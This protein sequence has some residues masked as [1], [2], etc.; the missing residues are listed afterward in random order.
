M[1]LQKF[2]IVGCGGSGGATLRYLMDQLRADLRHLGVDS[3]PAAWQFVHIDAPATPDVGPGTLGSIT[4]LGGRYVSV[5][6]PQNS[7]LATW[8]SVAARMERNHALPSLIGWAPS[9]PRKANNVP[10]TNGAGQYRAIGRMLT[11]PYL[12][13][14]HEQLDTAYKALQQPTAWGEMPS[15]LHSGNQAVIPIVVSSMAGGAG[16]GIFL[17]ACRL[18]G[19]LHGIESS[20]LGLFLY[21]ADVFNELP[22]SARSGVEGNALGS[23]G[24]II[25]AAART[26][27]PLEQEML[28]A[29][30][31]PQVGMDSAPFGRVFPIGAMVG[32]DGAIFGD[33][34]MHGI[35]RGLGRALAG[36]MMSEQATDNYVNRIL[37][38][39]NPADTDTRHLGWAQSPAD[40]TWGSMGYASVS[41]GRDRYEEYAAQRLSR[42]AVDHLMAGHR[43]PGSQLPDTE[44]LAALID[45]QLPY[46]LPGIG[47]GHPGQGTGQWFQTEAFPDSVVEPIAR[48]SLADVLTAIGKDGGPALHWYGIVASRLAASRSGIRQMVDERVY[49]WAESWATRLE[50]S[51]QTQFCDAAARYGLPYARALTARLRA[52]CEGLAESLAQ[53]GAVELDPV[54]VDAGLETRVHQLG[55]TEVGPGHPLVTEVSRNLMASTRGYAVRYAARLGARVLSSFAN[56]VLTALESAASD[57]LV[58]LEHATTK[59]ASQA[60]LAH[61]VS[62]TYRDWPTEAAAPPARFDEAVNEVLVTS[63]AEFPSQFAADVQASVPAAAGVYTDA[64]RQVRFEV[65]RGRWETT[66]GRIGEIEILTRA[67]RW[68]AQV[69]SHNS[70][71][72]TPTPASRPRYRLA[73][74]TREVLDR[75]RLWLDRPGQPFTVFSRQSLSD[76]LNDPRLADA[77]RADRQERFIRTFFEAMALARP[78]VGVSPQM[79]QALHGGQDVRYEYSFSEVGLVDSDPT[80]AAIAHRLRNDPQLEEKSSV[81]AFTK[82]LSK[83]D[84]GSGGARGARIALF[85]AYPKYSPLVF[86]SLLHPIHQRWTASSPEYLRQIWQWKR[87]RPLPAAVGMATEDLQATIAG[88]YLGRALGLVQHPATVKETGPV[89]VFDPQAGRWVK[90]PTLLL[91]LDR[92]PTS[93]HDWLAVVLASHCFAIAA[94]NQDP[95]LAALEPYRVLRSYYDNSVDQPRLGGVELLAGTDLISSWYT[96]G[97][98]PSGEPSGILKDKYLAA[99]DRHDALTSWLTRLR[100]S[101]RDTFLDGAGRQRLRSADQAVQEPLIVEISPLVVDALD[102]LLVLAE[103]ALRQAGEGGTDRSDIWAIDV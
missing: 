2:L 64:V 41:L 81:D 63:S 77:E 43:D 103:S 91:S 38:N 27:E 62:T 96:D 24:E 21:T 58:E 45:A 33:G 99:A 26:G 48:V 87:T 68:R 13:V 101:Y 49:A 35:Y 51:V 66:G 44:Q 9:D 60:G 31:L 47:L 5:S 54:S 102:Q 10:V 12:R 83:G 90:F 18:V 94:C 39:R 28:A 11:L 61:V 19:K 29:Q 22:E 14:M 72:R 67:A 7:Y 37:A 100:D 1:P 93:A 17:D 65:I 82:A 85:G 40:F 42:L 71:D 97:R 23:L 8:R 3:L 76:Y 57:G 69:L 16:A 95:T 75:A 6:S 53:A 80:A 98:W 20:N 30:G 86:A 59:A 56:D 89:R 36:I 55:R 74:S 84:Q 88:W 78:L 79:V 15:R 32:G 46:V 34:T 50:E 25:A 92:V 4:D 70:G 52:Y 73:V